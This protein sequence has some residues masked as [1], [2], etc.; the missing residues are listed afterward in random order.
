ML[1]FLDILS[2]RVRGVYSIL[3]FLYFCHFL[4]LCLLVFI[5]IS[6]PI[7]GVCIL[8]NVIASFCIDLF[9]IIYVLLCLSLC[10]CFKV[11][12]VWHDCYSWSLIS[13]WIKYLF[14]HFQSVSFVLMW[15][16]GG[17]H[18]AGPYFLNPINHSDFLK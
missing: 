16:S 4:P 10:L 9:I 1:F 8:M 7:L 5:Y 12:F 18:T 2:T 15:I 17:Q 11:C 13:I 6:A 14:P 3:P